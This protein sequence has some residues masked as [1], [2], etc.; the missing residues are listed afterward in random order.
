[1]Y[2]FFYRKLK[3][4]ARI[5]TSPDD[6]SIF[7]SPADCRLHTFETID[8]AKQ[9]WIKGKNFSLRTLLQDD[10]LANKF[11]GGSLVIAR[12][13]P[14]DYHR[15][16]FPVTGTVSEPK[17]ID[18]TYY[19]VNPVAVNQIIDV[20]GENKRAVATVETKE[21]GSVCF[22]AI[23]ATMVGSICLTAS[24]GTLYQKG[25]EYGYFAFGGSTCLILFEKGRVVF[26]ED[27]VVNSEKPL[28]TLVKMG[29]SIGRA[30]QA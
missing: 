13:A 10:D 3:V 23:G 14:Q 9:I 21:F 30:T 24:P 22:V 6:P 25:D 1:M 26:D 7:V 19:T 4:G 2:L 20:Y 16:H 11:E 5:I 27:L 17:H 8:S 15:F 28:E 18:G 12:L 29:T